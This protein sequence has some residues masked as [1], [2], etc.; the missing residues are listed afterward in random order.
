MRSS[1]FEDKA[2][3][4]A[5]KAGYK[6]R[7]ASPSDDAGAGADAG[8]EAGPTGTGVGANGGGDAGTGTGAEAG[9]DADA[10]R[11]ASVSTPVDATPDGRRG[12]DRT[13]G[14]KEAGE[15]RCGAQHLV[16]L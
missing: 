13:E 2:R 4:A 11:E 9:A 3:Q 12:D 7:L 1:T 15:P 14:L 16:V 10:S 8:T 5:L 6:A